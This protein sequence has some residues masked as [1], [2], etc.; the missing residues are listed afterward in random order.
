MYKY[1][2]GCRREVRRNLSSKKRSLARA[3]T[4]QMCYERDGNI[5]GFK[6][7]WDKP[8]MKRTKRTSK[9]LSKF[10]SGK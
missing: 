9:I 1:S 7:E 10:F 2:R 3:I 5:K 6:S 8:T 4:K